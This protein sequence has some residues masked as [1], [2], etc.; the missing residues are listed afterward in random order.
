MKKRIKSRTSFVEKYNMAVE[1]QTLIKSGNATMNDENVFLVLM[2]EI[3][4]YMN[5]SAK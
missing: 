5:L 4:E 2:S 3:R 1:L